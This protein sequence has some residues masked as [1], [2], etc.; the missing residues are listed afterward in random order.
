[1][2]GRQRPPTPVAN[3]DDSEVDND[4]LVVTVDRR[5]TSPVY[6]G[7][8]YLLNDLDSFGCPVIPWQLRS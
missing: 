7:D 5:G 2:G 8:S 3:T 4:T 1:M 6:S